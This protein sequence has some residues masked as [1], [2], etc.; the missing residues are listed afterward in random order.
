M[1]ESRTETREPANSP[2][3]EEILDAFESGQLTPRDPTA[4]ERQMLAAAAS[5]TLRK[6][7]RINIRLTGHDL[8]GIQ[9][10]AAEQG[11]PYQTLISSLIHQFVEG[12]LVRRAG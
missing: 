4:E 12:D 8:L 11:L 10:K 9:R 6:D 2:E 7:H 1:Q 3:E 5:N